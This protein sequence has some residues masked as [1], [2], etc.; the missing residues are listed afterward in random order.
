M[1]KS[2][3]RDLVLE[4][5]EDYTINNRSVIKED[6]QSRYLHGDLCCPVGKMLRP[7][8]LEEWHGEEVDN[9]PFPVADAFMINSLNPTGIEE[10]L[11][12]RCQLSDEYHFLSINQLSR[13]QAIHDN[14]DN[15]DENGLTDLGECYLGSLLSE[16]DNG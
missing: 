9:K 15:W 10:V 16:L 11:W 14:P 8:V 3:Q 7:D 6:N 13:L 5:F 2:L 1:N 4:L 12:M